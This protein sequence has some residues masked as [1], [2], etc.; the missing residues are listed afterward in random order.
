VAMIRHGQGRD[1]EARK[2]YEDIVATDP[3]AAVAANNLAWMYA[4]K[5]ERLDMALQLAQAAK[6]ELPDVAAVSDTL[7]F[8]FLKRDLPSLAI[9]QFRHAVEKEPGNPTFH[10]RLGQALF[11]NGNKDE[12]KRS[13]EQA[14]KLKLTG[15]E[16]AEARRMLAEVS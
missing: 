14:M 16:A 2:L 11:L 12:A 6:A 10:Y 7:G 9:P 13:L 8:V 15:D 1:E 5:G 3:R 4:E